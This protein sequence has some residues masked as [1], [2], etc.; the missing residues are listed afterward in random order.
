MSFF[1]QIRLNG[2]LHSDDNCATKVALPLPIAKL[3][4][5]RPQLFQ[6]LCDT[7]STRDHY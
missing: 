4:S 3:V 2:M 1:F 6:I 7:F 5:A